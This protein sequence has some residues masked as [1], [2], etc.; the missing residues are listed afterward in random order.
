MFMTTRPFAQS[1]TPD[2]PDLANL[3]RTFWDMA[4]DRFGAIKGAAG[5]DCFTWS[6][7]TT[8]AAVV[9]VLAGTAISELLGQNTPPDDDGSV[10]SPT[11]CAAK[12]YGGRHRVPTALAAFITTYDDLRH[13]G[14]PKQ[15]A[16][17]D[18]MHERGRARLCE[19]LN[20]A[21][22]V[23]AKVTDGMDVPYYSHASYR[24][25]FEGFEDDPSF[26]DG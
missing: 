10:P 14:P 15:Q 11:R 18:L 17:Y 19:L 3:Q 7:F 12:L 2:S 5:Q 13:F 6:K 26:S 24:F 20:A 21:G 8:E 23:W 9:I 1:T 22:D 16:I 25:T 4:V